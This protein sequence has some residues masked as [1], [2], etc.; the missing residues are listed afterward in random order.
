METHPVL[1]QE[2]WDETPPEVQVHIR[3]LEARLV[4][5]EAMV[6]PLQEQ[7]CAL[8]EQMNQTSC[9]SSRPP[10]SDPPHHKRLRW[11]RSKRRCG[12]QPGHPGHTRTLLSV[13]DFDE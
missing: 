1:P 2:L 12:G 5:L 3:A 11:H 9:N 6:Q 7:I 13:S 10:S 4:T 8:Q